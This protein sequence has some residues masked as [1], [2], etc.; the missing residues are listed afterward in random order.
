MRD[1]GYWSEAMSP[2]R[3]L[4]G[5]PLRRRL[6]LLA[7]VG[8]IPI[9]AM[10]GVG[11]YLLGH[12]QRIQA[13]RVGL[14]LARALAT[15]VDAEVRSS[16]SVL[17]SLATTVTLD[18]NDFSG[19]RVRAQ[20]VLRTQAH[21][22]A[23]M[24]ADP[25]GNRLADTRFE[26]HVLTP[27]IVDVESLQAVV[28]T[29]APAVGNLATVF[30]GT[31]AFAVRVPVVRDG[32]LR[33]VLSAIVSPEDILEVI[34]RQRVPN[35]WVIS[36]F[37]A[38]GRRVAR[39][40][41]HR[42][43]LGGK[44]APTLQQLMAGGAAEGWGQT[45]SLEGDRIYTSYSKLKD[46]GWTVAPGIPAALV[47][48]AAYRSFAAY[49]GGILLS[50]AL[51]ALAAVR[52]AR[53]INQPIGQLRAAAQALG[54]RETLTPP[55]TSI[56]EIRDVA[57]ALVIAAA[58]REELL[59]KEQDARETAEAAGRAKDQ[60]LALLSHE[61]RTPL[62][63]VYG[64][65]RML[66]SGQVREEAA[67]RAL[68]AVVRNANAQVQLIDDL[69]D[70]SRVI[71]GK[72]RLDVRPLDLEAVVEAALDAVRP[73][74]EAKGIRLQKLLDPWAGPTTGDPSRLQQVVW[75]LLANAVK[76]TPKGGRVEVHLRRVDS[77]V[78]IVVSDTGEGIA[79]A[80]LPYVFDRF[81]Q[82]DS[83]S[84]RAHSGLG[85]GLAL[86]K[87]L[88][89]LH[90][91]SVAAR[92]AGEGQ[93]ATFIVTL[94]VTIAQLPADASAPLHPT[95]ASVDGRPA[96]ARLDG[97]RVLV[98][99]D[100][101][102]ALEIGTAILTAAGADVRTCRSASEGLDVLT[103]WRPHVLV[104]DIEMPG[105]DG[106]ALIRNVRALHPD[107]GGRTPA[108]ALTAY[109]RNQDRISS[110]SAGYHMHVPKPVDPAELTTIIAS[111][112]AWPPQP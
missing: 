52:V 90:G 1:S 57:D 37:D 11:L 14:E 72:M 93:G 53:S 34:Q 95:A 15:G 16:I 28:R 91:G 56:Q 80:I 67:A 82:A 59:R 102:D 31:L 23:V 4:P 13:E 97:L 44:A 18:R 20:R 46:S 111:L 27:P 106:Y 30:D 21:W 108:V 17:E 83:S 110:L 45:F 9:A 92:S 32:E 87:H 41:A 26:A 58:Q 55:A 77:H 99:D 62:N 73:A 74:A 12:Q 70:V 8:I 10:S 101:R 33:Y 36:V 86:V 66:Q 35:D 96:G 75:N 29:R 84:T 98:V 24:L 3:L 103:R 60:F 107:K 19:F 85:L 112:A 76:F 65:A 48:G 39:S 49:G 64:W 105:E 61:L 79:P 63:A 71:T 42:E 7:A 40:R 69:L 51:G 5:V 6:F 25:S 38:N 94:P 54:R 43:N 78:E 2:S 88:V 47:E 89:E 22:L 50:I 109:G 81:R 104:S 68:D 100:D